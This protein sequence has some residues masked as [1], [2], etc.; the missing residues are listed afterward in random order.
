MA[1]YKDGI[2]YVDN[3]TLST[4]AQCPT[5]A[6][7]RYG[8]NLKPRGWSAAPLQAGI[9]IHQAIEK[10]YTGGSLS[11]V[12]DTFHAAYYDWAVANVE[13][14]DRL[15]Y[16]NV[17]ECVESWVIRNPIDKLPYIIPSP[18]HIEMPFDLQLNPDDPTIRYVGR[19]D[20]LVQRKAGRQVDSEYINR[21]AL[22]VLDTKSSGAPYGNW[23]KQFELSPQMTGYTW[24]AKQLFP[25]ATVSGIYINVVHTYMI[26]REA[27]KCRQH[28]CDYSECRFMHPNHQLIG[29][30]LRAA[31]EIEEWRVDAYNL[32]YNW[33]QMLDQQADGWDL[34]LVPQFGKWVYQACSLCE[35]QQF[36]RA[37]RDM[38]NYDF[39]EESWI[40]G[41]LATR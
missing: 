4:L 25:K 13:I 10:H 1:H 6:M 12:L 38:N 7:V 34:N 8:Y 26:P 22:Y 32:A 27:G 36:C 5:R 3:T 19:V 28:K 18:D 11:E 40:P 20:A 31:G 23:A 30:I 16:T 21:E 37:G 2:L 9:A 15:G 33:K 24:A 41:D 39:E 17:M 35:L 14:G 29:P